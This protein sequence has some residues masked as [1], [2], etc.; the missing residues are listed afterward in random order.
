MRQP[1][2]VE[3]ILSRLCEEEGWYS[4]RFEKVRLGLG[5]G[6]E[7]YRGQIRFPC[8]IPM[9]WCLRETDVIDLEVDVIIERVKYTLKREEER[10]WC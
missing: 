10:G 2:L 9:W 1:I 6:I 3:E 4:C 7:C 8:H 5:E